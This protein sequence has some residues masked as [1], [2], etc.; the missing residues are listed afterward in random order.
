MSSR[1]RSSCFSLG[2]KVVLGFFFSCRGGGRAALPPPRG[3]STAPGI[4]EEGRGGLTAVLGGASSTAVAERE[5]SE[6]GE[7]DDEDE[8]EPEPELELEKEPVSDETAF[9]LLAC[10]ARA[11]R[12]GSI[13]L[14]RVTCLRTSRSCFG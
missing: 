10:S 7:E 11:R 4:G 6:E 9:S 12:S 5:V 8:D 14:P 1:L 3:I 2:R 13:F